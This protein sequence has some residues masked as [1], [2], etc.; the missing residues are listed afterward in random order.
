MPSHHSH[1]SAIPIDDDI[2][3]AALDE[4][5]LRDAK[6]T[7]TVVIP[8][9]NEAENIAWVLSR[10]PDWVDDIVVVDGHSTDNTIDVVL[11]HRPEAR[12]VHQNHRGKGNALRCG[13]DAA[14]GDVIVMLDGDGSTDPAEIPRF[15]AALRTGAD[16][17]KG[18][19]FVSGGGSADITPM[20][21]CGNKVLT[22]MVNQLWGSKFSD[23]CYGYNAFWRRCLPQLNPDSHG[24]EV[25]TL[26]ALRALRHD[27]KVVEVPSYEGNRRSGVS[28]LNARRDGIRVL[29]T[30]MA[31]R[32]R[33]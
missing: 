7:V 21:S 17:A 15:I 18:T 29:R 20:R 13:F 31:E 27:L 1:L 6:P 28:N 25:E 9:L 4:I 24:F 23:L 2:R 30:I 22:S 12:I 19:R 8:T 32:L 16:F 14:H 5:D 3:L 10:M 33:P 11:R 26:L